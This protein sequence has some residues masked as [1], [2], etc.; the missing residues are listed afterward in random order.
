MAPPA[1][2]VPAYYPGAIETPFLNL[3]LIGMSDDLAENFIVLDTQ[4]SG[5][6]VFSF[7]GRIGIVMPQTNDYSFNNIAGLL[8]LGQIPAGGDDTTFLR[9]DGSWASPVLDFTDI[10]G[11][12]A[13]SQ[14][15]AGGSSATFLRGDGSWATT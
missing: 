3:S 5:S 6:S 14:I 13:L 10:T 8:S 1:A 11:A 9:G 2:P 12:L 4:V 7:G 15:P